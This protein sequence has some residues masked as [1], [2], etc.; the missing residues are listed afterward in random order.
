MAAVVVVGA[1]VVPVVLAV[2]AVA[3][4]EVVGES[5]AR[6]S[7]RASCVHP[8]TNADRATTA[9]HLRTQPEWHH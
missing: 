1:T 9:N 3:V 7:G 4:A 2:D 5:A 8:L 6:T